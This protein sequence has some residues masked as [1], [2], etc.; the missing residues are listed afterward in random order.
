MT[1]SVNPPTGTVTNIMPLGASRVAGARPLYESYRYELWK[2]LIDGNY[3]FDFIG[4]ETD[5][6]D[7]PMHNGQSFDKNH[8]GRGGISSGGILAELEIWLN[9]LTQVPDIVLFSSPGGNDGFTDLE[10]TVANVNAIIDIFQA[11]NPN[12]TIFLELP[13]PAL[14]SEQTPEFLAFYNMA[15]QRIPQI[16][17]AKTTATSSVLTVDMS[18]NFTDAYLADDVHYSEAGA[19]F[20]S[21]R[22]LDVLAPILQ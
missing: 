2:L 1:N 3:N 12:V 8:E 18:T 9:D 14:S 13:A 19:R 4:T 21:S 17:A 22:Y 5:P 10:Q 15:L 16:A 20:I 6:A 11:R 7:Y